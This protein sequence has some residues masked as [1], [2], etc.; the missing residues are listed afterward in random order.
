MHNRFP[1]IL[2]E[3]GKSKKNELRRLPFNLSW[4][5]AKR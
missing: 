2:I 5:R 3:E 4:I 1:S